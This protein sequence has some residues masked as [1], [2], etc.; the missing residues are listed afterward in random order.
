MHEQQ[1][2]PS[3][4]PSPFP[5]QS[6][7]VLILHCSVLMVPDV[8]AGLIVGFGTPGLGLGVGAGLGAAGLVLGTGLGEA[9][10]SLGDT[11]DLDT[12]SDFALCTACSMDFA[13]PLDSAS[14]LYWD[15]T[16]TSTYPS[17][18]LTTAYVFKCFQ[19]HLAPFRK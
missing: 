5:N 17:P 13:A 1:P 7:F 14:N 8:G 19:C 2:L 3:P 18:G 15:T 11:V 16:F 12:V 10:V 4:Y 6:K 9:V